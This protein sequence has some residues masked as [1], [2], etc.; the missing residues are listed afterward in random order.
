MVPES[1]A[2]MPHEFTGLLVSGGHT[3]IT[4]HRGRRTEVLGETVDD[5]VGEAYDKSAKILGL[6]FPGGPVMDRLAREGNPEAVRFTKPKQKNRFD[7]SYS[8]IKTAVLYHVQKQR[9][10]EGWSE[11]DEK[12]LQKDVAAGFQRDAIN[13][14]VEKTMDAVAF[15]KT[16][17]VAVGGGVSAN[18]YLRRRMT[19][20]ALAAG[21]K[22]WL[23][24][25]PLSGDNAAMIACRGFQ[26][27]KSRKKKFPLSLTANPN[28]RIKSSL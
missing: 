9:S 28:L 11:E 1:G 5:A 12:K 26:I 23:S 22:L 8:G 3:M 19:E 15:K 7:F 17:H 4:H 2:K 18:S 24:P 6:G 10:R 13:W 16:R 20:E 21:I 14:L 25:L 27:F